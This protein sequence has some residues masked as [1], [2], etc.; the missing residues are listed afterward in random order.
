MNAVTHGLFFVSVKSNRE[1]VFQ[2]LAEYGVHILDENGVQLSAVIELLTL[3]DMFSL[4]LS[5]LGINF[6]I[7]LQPVI[8]TKIAN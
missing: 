4:F 2:I 5:F 8:L 1:S 7:S 6:S 3:V